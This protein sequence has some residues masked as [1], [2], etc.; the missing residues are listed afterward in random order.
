MRIRVLP[1]VA[2]IVLA[3]AG[4][5]VSGAPASAASHKVCAIDQGSVYDICFEADGDKFIVND[6][7]KDGMRAVVKWKAM[8]GSGRVGQCA[9]TDGAF[10]SPKVCDYDFKE[11]PQNYVLFTGFI[12]DGP[13]GAAQFISYTYTGYISAK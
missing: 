4:T 1:A 3:G 10:N 7:R 13:R 5:L 9:D 11:G 6:L 2:A 8:D 12:Q